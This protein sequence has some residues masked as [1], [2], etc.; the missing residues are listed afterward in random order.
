VEWGILALI[1]S[2]AVVSVVGRG[3]ERF[4][5]FV[6]VNGDVYIDRVSPSAW[7]G[8]VEALQSISWLCAF[9]QEDDS[10]ALEDWPVGM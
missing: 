6:R 3:A 7:L 8:T 5:G 9:G 1:F 2:K 10:V 4:T